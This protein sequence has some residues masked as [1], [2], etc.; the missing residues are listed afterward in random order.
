MKRHKK[1]VI[2]KIN[3]YFSFKESYFLFSPIETLLFKKKIPKKKGH[4][5]RPIFRDLIIPLSI[6]VILPVTYYGVS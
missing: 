6:W 3:L 1:K 2:L 5:M 4:L